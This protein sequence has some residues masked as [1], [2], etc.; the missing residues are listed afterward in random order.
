MLLCC[1][2]VLWL[3]GGEDMWGHT[4]YSVVVFSCLDQVLKEDTC[5]DLEKADML[6][7]EARDLAYYCI[8]AVCEVAET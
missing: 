7:R 8:S 3:G 4:V 2:V 6:V 5:Q 1:S